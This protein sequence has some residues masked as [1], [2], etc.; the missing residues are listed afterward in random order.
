MDALAKAKE[1]TH[2]SY[3]EAVDAVCEG[4]KSVSKTMCEKLLQAEIAFAVG[5]QQREWV[6]PVSV[7]D[8]FSLCV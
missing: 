8:S 3:P 5:G 4:A 2:R 1:A 6:Q 7:S